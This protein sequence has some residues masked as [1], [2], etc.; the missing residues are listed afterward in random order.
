MFYIYIVRETTIN[1]YLGGGYYPGSGGN[2][3]SSTL[4]SYK[5]NN[6]FISPMDE[7]NNP[8]VPPLKT[9]YLVPAVAHAPINIKTHGIDVDF[10]QVGFLKDGE[11]NIL[12]LM[13]RNLYNGRDKSQYYT[14]TNTGAVNTRLPCKVKGRSCTGEYG[15]DSIYDGDSMFVEGLDKEMQVK[16]YENATFR[17]I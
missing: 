13:G 12:P 3:L 9:G 7:L 17:Y 15:C 16:L 5:G 2:F 10:E 14:M 4:F 1:Q 11:S 6:P 8:Y